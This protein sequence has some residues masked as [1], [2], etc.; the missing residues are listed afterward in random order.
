MGDFQKE[1][2]PMSTKQ[3]TIFLSAL[4]LFIGLLTS[5]SLTFKGQAQNNGSAQQHSPLPGHV[6]YE[7]LFRRHEFYKRKAEELER[8][9]K[10]SE[11]VRSIIKDEAKLDDEQA[12]AFDEAASACLREA[13]EL[14]DRAEQI[15]K[16]ARSRYPQG[17]IP[18]GETPPPVPQELLD[19]QQQRDDVFQRGRARL[20]AALG[21]EKFQQI[22]EF[23]KSK[24]SN[25]AR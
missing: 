20:Q 4:A 1:S 5:I 24:F 3:A 9:G 17:R 2:T 15:I 6:A 21:D 7:F 22:D 18:P 23:V 11:T 19:M 13:K 16:D 8:Q 25:K 10:N 12:A 14:D